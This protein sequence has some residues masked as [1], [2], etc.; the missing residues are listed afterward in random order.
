MRISLFETIGPVCPSCRREQDR[1]V[2]L[3]LSTVDAVCP[4]D[5]DDV[6]HGRLHCPGC[7]REYPIIDGIP[8]LMVSVRDYIQSS[9]LQLHW[10]DDLP[11]AL[12]SL[13]GDCCGPGSPYEL[14]RYY[15]STYAWGHYHDL[16]PEEPA[17]GSPHLLRALDGALQLMGPLPAGPVLDLGCSVGRS[18]LH[19]AERTGRAVL[20]LDVNFSMLRLA[21]MAARGEVSYPLRRGGL[22]YTRRR[23]PVSL[24]GAERVDFWVADAT[25]LPLGDGRLAG[26]SSINLLDCVN[27]PYQHLL[28]VERVLAPGGWAAVGCPY[29]WSSSATEPHLWLG[30]H[31]ARGGEAGTSAELLRALLTPGARPGG[32]TRLRLRA[33]LEDIPWVVRLHDRSRMEYAVHL[34]IAQREAEQQPGG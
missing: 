27:N 29:D 23:F 2:P 32:L 8:V 16:D 33:E 18:T 31:S 7:M 30:G 24:P 1:E 15:L 4:D 20:G 3:L 5:A 28:E 17:S 9:V 10:R 11:L 19:L 26:L 21:R 6:L 14:T 22:V 25:I 34:A 12:D 13:I